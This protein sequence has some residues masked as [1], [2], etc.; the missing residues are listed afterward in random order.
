ARQ[1]WCSRSTLIVE[2]ADQNGLGSGEAAPLPGYSRDTLDE[3]ERAPLAVPRVALQR[4]LQLSHP[5]Q[6]LQTAESLIAPELPSARFALETALLDRLRG[7]RRAPGWGLLRQALT[8][9]TE[10]PA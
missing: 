3:A 7:P 1:Q 5:A 9:C 4:A 10:A 2:I 6:L 8:L